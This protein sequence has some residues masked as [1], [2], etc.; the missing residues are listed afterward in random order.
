MGQYSDDSMIYFRKPEIDSFDSGADPCDVTYNDS[1]AGYTFGGTPSVAEIDSEPMP[2]P[3]K[4]RPRRTRRKI[5]VP[6]TYIGGFKIRVPTLKILL[7]LIA[8]GISLLLKFTLLWWVLAAL[9]FFTFAGMCVAKYA[10]LIVPQRMLSCILSLLLVFLAAFGGGK[11]PLSIQKETSA[12]TA[13]K[14]A[15]TAQS[16]EKTAEGGTAEQTT[17]ESASGEAG[18][19]S[20][21]AETPVAEATPTEQTATGQS[22]VSQSTTEASATA[23][24]TTEA[25]ATEASAT[26]ETGTLRLSHDGINLDMVLY[27]NE[28]GGHYYHTTPTCSSTT[29]EYHPFTGTLIYEELSTGKYKSLLRCSVCNAPVR[30]HTH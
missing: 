8:T 30:P 28:N 2:Q 15:A 24:S 1:T 19:A 29:A 12:P 20:M 3:P 4:P 5:R 11:G 25:S 7:L 27:Y 26:E 10:R 22:S 9:G 23:A 16:A 6:Y 18:T 21:S 13:S 17:E 14:T